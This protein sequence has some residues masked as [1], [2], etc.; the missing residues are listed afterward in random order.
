M[1]GR[2]D[3]RRAKRSNATSPEN[4]A[5][6]SPC[7]RLAQAASQTEMK[8]VERGMQNEE[9]TALRGHFS[10]FLIRHSSFSISVSAFRL[11]H[12]PYGELAHRLSP[13]RLSPNKGSRP[14]AG[15]P[16]ARRL[17]S[18]SEGVCVGCRCGLGA[19]CLGSTGDCRRRAGRGGPRAGPSRKPPPASVRGYRNSRRYVAELTSSRRRYS[20]LISRCGSLARRSRLCLSRT[21]SESR[22]PKPRRTR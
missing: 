19:R 13:H 11:R 9:V 12:P 14:L 17:V 10:S 22:Q 18:R 20:I 21:T 6:Q 2:P 1:R 15:Q 4:G 16:G 3:A 7:A 8:N 5:K